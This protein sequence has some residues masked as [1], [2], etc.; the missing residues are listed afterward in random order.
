MHTMRNIDRTHI[1]AQINKH[2]N[3]GSA[4]AQGLG[5]GGPYHGREGGGGAGGRELGRG[6][7]NP[8]PAGAGGTTPWRGRGGG[9]AVNMPPAIIYTPKHLSPQKKYFLKSYFC[10]F[11]DDSIRQLILSKVCHAAKPWK[12]SLTFFKCRGLR[13]MIENR[14]RSMKTRRIPQ[15]RGRH[16]GTDPICR[17]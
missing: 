9:R 10:F 17:G 3:C 5:P 12:H 11:E 1:K 8:D 16:Y 2:V 15:K 7:E 6:A 14:I 13:R 4:P